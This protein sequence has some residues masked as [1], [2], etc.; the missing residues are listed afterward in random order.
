MS[1]RINPR[2]DAPEDATLTGKKRDYLKN[3]GSGLH[4][5]T[6]S[7]HRRAIRRRVWNTFQD[8]RV[9]FDHLSEE[10]RREIF[11][12]E[13]GTSEDYALQRALADTIGFIYAGLGG[14]APFEHI[15]EAGVARGEYLLGNV[16]LARRAEVDLQVEYRQP[17]A[18]DMPKVIEAMLDREYGRLSRVEL[19]TFVHHA[20][21]EGLVSDDEL[22]ELLATFEEREGVDAEMPSYQDAVDND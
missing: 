2:N 1:Y 6:Q 17:F 9:L 4:P 21:V 20:I 3:D 7:D 18:Q 22:N 15:V 13:N 11:D 5:S 19:S 8:F 16:D 10:E 12:V 14:K